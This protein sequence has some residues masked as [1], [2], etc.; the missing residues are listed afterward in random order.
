M[1]HATLTQGIPKLLDPKTRQFRLFNAKG[2]VFEG[3]PNEALD[4]VLYRADRQGIDLGSLTFAGQ[5]LPGVSFMGLNLSGA[6]F[7]GAGLYKAN[8]DKADISDCSFEGAHLPE[9]S[10]VAADITNADFTGTNLAGADFTNA[11]MHLAAI[12]EGAHMPSVKNFPTKETQMGADHLEETKEEQPYPYT[13]D[14]LPVKFVYLRKNTNQARVRNPFMRWSGEP[15]AVVA[16]VADYE[17][18][19]IRFSAATCHFDPVWTADEHGEMTLSPGD[20]FNKVKARMF[21]FGRLEKKALSISLS[22]EMGMNDVQRAVVETI[23]SIQ[24]KGDA[25][26]FADQLFEAAYGKGSAMFE[27]WPET[28]TDGYEAMMGKYEE[29]AALRTWVFHTYGAKRLHRACLNWMGRDFAPRSKLAEIVQFYS[30]K[31]AAWFRGAFLAEN[32]RAITILTDDY[33]AAREALNADGAHN[34][35]T[36]ENAIKIRLEMIP[37]ASV[38]DLEAKLRDI[39][40]KRLAVASKSEFSL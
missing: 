40:P 26:E 37:A 4:F 17:K 33:S 9:A 31:R 5:H 6:D 25:S 12:T 32:E 1:R 3:R 10:F 30:A 20:T 11:V 39:E 19:E 24:S 18:F 28:H 35:D 14:G 16:F 13:L 2:I 34:R 23:L 27:D 7:S 29:L 36:N 38:P 22:N 15:L 21:A 8:F